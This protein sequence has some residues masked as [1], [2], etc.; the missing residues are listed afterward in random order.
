MT[1]LS[2][3]ILENWQV[4]K[5]KKQKTA[6]IEFMQSKIPGLRVEQGGFGNNRNLVLGDVK[7]ADVILGAHYDTCARLPFPNFLPPKNILLYIGYSLLIC[8]PFGI[9]AGLINAALHMVTDD[10]FITYWGTF[11]PTM[12]LV[13][14][15]FMGGKP[16]PHTVND[17]TSGV[18][19]LCEIWAAMSDEQRAKT[20]FVFFDNE[21]NG[22]LGSAFFRKLHKKDGLK[23]KLMINYDCVSDGEHMLFVLNKPALKVYGDDFVAAFPNTAEM[24]AHVESSSDTMYPSDQAGFPV[25]VGVAAMKKKRFVGLY[26]D[27]I[28]TVRDTVM[29]RENIDYL[30]AG[31][32]RL[33]NKLR[34]EGQ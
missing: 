24:T 13:Y 34:G 4:R 25:G 20:A 12:A 27:R 1:P 30:T 19:T 8:L 14:Y 9:V 28:H 23:N 31:T 5:T 6:F 21:E 32:L 29:R 26:V 3:T 33:L 16:N 10:F 15:L 7:S 17:N 18:I 2:E 22:L 11:L